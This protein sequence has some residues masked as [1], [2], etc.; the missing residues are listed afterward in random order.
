MNKIKYPPTLQKQCRNRIKLKFSKY[1]NSWKTNKWD[2]Y[3]WYKR[4]EQEF[5]E[6]GETKLY[7]NERQ[8]K[9]ELLDII[10]VC[11]MAYARTLK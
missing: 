11:Q 1:K 5:N 9:N 4:I 6:L 10:N 7:N 3:D 8:F 2:N